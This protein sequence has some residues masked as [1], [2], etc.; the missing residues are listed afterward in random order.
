[1]AHDDQDDKVHLDEGVSADSQEPVAVEAANASLRD[2]LLRALAE[3]ENTRRR[4]DEA[5][6][7]GANTGFPILRPSFCRSQIICSGRSPR[8][9]IGLTRRRATPCFSTAFARP[10]ASSS[11]RWGDLAS[12]ASRPSALP[13]IPISTRRWPRWMTIPARREA[14][15]AFWRT[16]T[17]STIVYCDLL[18]SLS[19]SRDWKLRGLSTR[20]RAHEIQARIEG[21]GYREPSQTCRWMRRKRSASGTSWVYR[22]LAGMSHGRRPGRTSSR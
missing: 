16:A 3:V 6:W 15:C 4:A 18:V 1:M 22:R 14:S 12:N 20:R 13:S 21:E 10:S 7:M 19:P 5:W 2:R 9:R 17:R 11:R 8:R